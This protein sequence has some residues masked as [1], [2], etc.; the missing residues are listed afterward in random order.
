VSAKVKFRGGYT[1]SCVATSLPVVEEHMILLG[2]IK[3]SITIFQLGWRN[4][5]GAS[6]GTHSQGGCTDVGQYSDAQ[7]AVWREAGW[8]MQHRTPAQGF[9]NHAHGW[10][11]GCTHLAP[12]GRAQNTQWKWRQNGL[13]SRGPI[14]GKWPVPDWRTGMKRLEE[15]NVTLKDD[16]AAE[17]V[18]RLRADYNAIADAVLNRDAV[19]NTV[20][21]NPK[22]PTVSVKTILAEIG[23][24]TENIAGQVLQTDNLVG[25]EYDPASPN[26]GLAAATALTVLLRRQREQGAELDAILAAQREPQA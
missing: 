24:N 5:V 3:E 4:D 9:S 7:I 16:I 18:K 26:K 12:A 20:T 19:P 11:F 14:Q 17:V 15:K 23:K 6:A 1:C 22:N 21:G 2:L 8:T 13:V 25:N 10:P